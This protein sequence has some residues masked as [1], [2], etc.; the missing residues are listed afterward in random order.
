MNSEKSSWKLMVMHFMM[1]NSQDFS[2]IIWALEL[3]WN[4][5]SSYSICFFTKSSHFDCFPLNCSHF[6]T[7]WAIDSRLVSKESY[8]EVVFGNTWDKMFNWCF[9]SISELWLNSWSKFSSRGQCFSCPMW[10]TIKEKFPSLH[11]LKLLQISFNLRPIWY[12]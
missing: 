3:I 12:Q 2:T 6:Q 5:M 4:E 1:C 8:F 7:N 10:Y 11:F 9:E